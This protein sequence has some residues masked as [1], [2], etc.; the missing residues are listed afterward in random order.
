MGRIL[1]ADD[2]PKLGR[3]VAEM[4]SLEGHDVRRVSGGAQ[5]ITELQESGADVVITDLKMPEVDGFQATRAIRARLSGTLKY[6]A[7]A[8]LI[9]EA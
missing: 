6:S 4:L 7:S 3:V 1:V 5:A 2:E 8:Y 9:L